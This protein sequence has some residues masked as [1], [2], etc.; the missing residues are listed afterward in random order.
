MVS[1]ILLIGGADP[2]PWHPLSAVEDEFRLLF[3]DLGELEV[4]TD[5]GRLARL[6]DDSVRLLVCYAD[7]WEGVLSDEHTAGLIRFAAGGGR[8][9]VIHNGI[10]YQGRPEFQAVVGARF[11]GHPPLTKLGFRSAAP[12]HPINRGLA[13]E[14]ELDEEPY[15]F[16]F[17]PAKIE[18]LQ[19]YRHEGVW[20]PAAWTAPFGKGTLVYLMPG[21]TVASF[22]HPRYRELIRSSAR[23]LLTVR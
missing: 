15:R 4:T 9:L 6:E 20:Y 1:R 19:E 17:H 3:G 7:L 2:A 23:W 13:S 10:S 5:D 12:D 16:E 11:T 22:R 14:W 18:V 21:H 8:L